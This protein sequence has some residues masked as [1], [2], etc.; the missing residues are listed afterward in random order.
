MTFFS[1]INDLGHAQLG[2]RVSQPF[3]LWSTFPNA[4]FQRFSITVMNTKSVYRSLLVTYAVYDKM[5]NFLYLDVLQFFHFVPRSRVN[6]NKI[7]FQ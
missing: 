6:L 2:S 4:A 5:N 3:G 7:L 1:S